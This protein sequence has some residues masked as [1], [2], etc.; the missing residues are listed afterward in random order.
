MYTQISLHPGSSLTLLQGTYRN[1]T[2]FL[3]VGHNISIHHRLFPWL[4]PLRGHWSANTPENVK[5]NGMGRYMMRYCL[6]DTDGSTPK[7]FHCESR[8]QS[9]S[10]MSITSVAS[11]S[12]PRTPD[13]H[14]DT[15][16]LPFCSLW[17]RLYCKSDKR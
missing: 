10:E 17:S 13:P 15:L 7:G 1:R 2:H 14:K 11:R 16:T 6:R 8:S 12:P 5:K 4:H 3:L 9:N